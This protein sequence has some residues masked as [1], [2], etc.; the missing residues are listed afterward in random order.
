MGPE[1]VPWPACRYYPCINM[2]TL[3][4]SF[5]QDGSLSAGW[6]SNQLALKC[7]HCLLHDIQSNVVTVVRCDV[8]TAVFSCKYVPTFRKGLNPPKVGKYLPSSFRRLESYIKHSTNKCTLIII[9]IIII[10]IFL[11]IVY[12][13]CEPVQHVSISSWDHHQGHMWE[14]KL[15]KLKPT[16]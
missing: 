3:K 1:H 8:L 4:K 13:L 10:A 11:D 9:I 5:N 2:W 7:K 12:N 6:V 16:I 14:C 15:H